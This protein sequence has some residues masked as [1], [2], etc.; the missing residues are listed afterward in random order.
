MQDWA[1]SFKN[2]QSIC[3]QFFSSR[4]IF[5][6]LS[7]IKSFYTISKVEK[8]N[9]WK[10]KCFFFIF[11]YFFIAF[12]SRFL[13]FKMQKTFDH[14]TKL[15]PLPLPTL[16]DT[17]KKYL[18]SG[19]QFFINGLISFTL[20]FACRNEINSCKSVPIECYILLV[21]Q[22]GNIFIFNYLVT[23]FHG[24]LE[25]RRRRTTRR[26]LSFSCKDDY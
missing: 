5:G 22:S 12:Y 9:G 4:K 2:M 24:N 18:D 13:V 1:L 25:E 17:C 10:W 21:Y 19:K 7:F 6:I 11:F 14:Q 8:I 23:S 15:P 16:E 26:K 3:N 20:A